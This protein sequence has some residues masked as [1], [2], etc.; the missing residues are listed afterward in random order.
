MFRYEEMI[1]CWFLLV[2]N[3]FFDL[4]NV[5][6][7]GF[8]ILDNYFFIVGG[9]RIISQEI[10]VVY[11][12]NFSINEW[13]QVVFMNQKRFNFKFV[14]VNL[15]FYVIG[16]QVVFNVEC[17]NFEQDVWNFVVFL[18][19][20]LVE[21]FVCECKGKIYVIGG[22]IIR[23]WNMNILQYC[24]FF[25]IWM[26]F[27]ICDVYICK[28]QMVF[29]EEIIYI[30]GGCFYELG[31]NC[32]SSQSEDM[33]IV[34][35]YNIIICQWFYF[36]ENMFKLGFNLICVFYNDGIYIMSR[37]VILLISLEY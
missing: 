19:N 18:F 26:L 29:V 3:F 15:K 32:R 9:Y 25:D 6:G 14:V 22:Y 28:Q 8:V 31:F 20:F 2:N 11:F 30:V 10:F 23:D 17:Y 21:F 4:V 7:Y 35:F 1:E 5:R 34:Q 12:Y 27:E 37:D 33:F 24:F 36:K 16:G 13:F